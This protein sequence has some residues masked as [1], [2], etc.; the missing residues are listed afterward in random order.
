VA[1]LQECIRLRI[2]PLPEPGIGVT[3]NVAQI[4]HR[5]LAPTRAQPINRDRTTPA[6]TTT[7]ARAIA[8]PP[9]RAADPADRSPVE[10]SA[11]RTASP[12]TACGAAASGRPASGERGCQPRSRGDSTPRAGPDAGTESEARTG[13][14]CGSVSPAPDAPPAIGASG[15]GV[16]QTGTVESSVGGASRRNLRWSVIGIGAPD[17][18]PRQAPC[19]GRIRRRGFV[20][21]KRRRSDA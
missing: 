5:I 13:L 3:V 15:S 14:E 6:T 17:A 7:P 21:S 11:D 2:L 16:C 9:N 1:R 20:S 19:S 12:A 18:R 8:R 10:T 4:N